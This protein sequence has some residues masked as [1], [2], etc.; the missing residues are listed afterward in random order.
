MHILIIFLAAYMYKSKGFTLH[1]TRIN[2]RFK[3]GVL[4]TKKPVSI[5]YVFSSFGNVTKR[6][7]N[8]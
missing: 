1:K 4:E 7:L 8:T 2:E 6:Y 3:A 5:N